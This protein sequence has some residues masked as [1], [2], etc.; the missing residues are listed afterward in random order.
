MRVCWGVGWAGSVEVCSETLS[1]GDGV[2]LGRVCEVGGCEEGGWLLL[3][4][5]PLLGKV[6]ASGRGERRVL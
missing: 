1:V 2:M 3:L 6:E 5:L 4:L